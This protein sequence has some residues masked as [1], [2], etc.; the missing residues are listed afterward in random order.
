MEWGSGSGLGD[1]LGRV[2]LKNRIRRDKGE[3]FSLKI[4][5]I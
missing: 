1:E 3:L 2:S 4:D 5:Q